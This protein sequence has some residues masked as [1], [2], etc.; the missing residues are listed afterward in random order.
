MKTYRVTIK[1]R[2]GEQTNLLSTIVPASNERQ[3]IEKVIAAHGLDHVV[4]RKAEL[5]NSKNN[6]R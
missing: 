2:K 1:H 5:L 6:T 3:A 4:S